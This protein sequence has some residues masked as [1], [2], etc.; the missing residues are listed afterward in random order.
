MYRI[1]VIRQFVAWHFL[2]VPGAG[3][4][5]VR[6]SHNYRL[7]LTLYGQ[8]LDR[9]G[10]LADLDA[11]RDL[12]DEVM[13]RYADTT[14]ND[15]PEF[16]GLNPSL[17][18]FARVIGDRLARTVDPV[19]IERVRVTLWEDENTWA[20]WEGPTAR[21]RAAWYDADKADVAA[22]VR[23]DRSG[24]GRRLAVPR[25]AATDQADDRIQTPAESG[26]EA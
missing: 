1:G 24:G 20:S 2:T 17:E 16:A 5:G 22:S 9:C 10:Y 15:A 7:E 14:L 12:V 18:H 3:S 21:A 23:A 6:H 4:E 25:P 11:V 26:G 19:R 8:T 13:A